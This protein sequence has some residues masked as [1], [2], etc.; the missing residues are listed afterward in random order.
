MGHARIVL[1][2]R[3]EL[4]ISIQNQYMDDKTATIWVKV[5]EGRSKSILIGGIYR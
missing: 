4:T 2:A 3:N 5:G 1:I